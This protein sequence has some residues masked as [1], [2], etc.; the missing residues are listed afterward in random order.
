MQGLIAIFLQKGDTVRVLFFSVTA[1]GGHN[2][3]A[4][5]VAE[6]LAQQGVQ[7]KIVD[8][9]RLSG[10][11]MYYTVSRGYLLASSYLKYGYGAVYRVLEHR[12]G[13]A[14]RLSP[15]RL[16]GRSLAKK[17]AAVIREYDPDVVVC[18]H[19]FA[20]RILDIAKERH[21]FR[22]KT[23]GIVTDFTL[24]PYWEEALRLDRL[25]LACEGL[26]PLAEKKGFTA[27]QI[28]PT[29]IPVHSAF[30]KEEAKETARTAL[31]LS[32]TLPTLLIMGGS[33][34]Y[35]NMGKLLRR[36]DRLPLALQS[37]VVCGS[38]ERAAKSIRRH[39]PK[40]PVLVL[41]FVDFVPRLMAAA[42]L[43]I[44]KPGGLTT[45]EALSRRLPMIMTAAIPGHEANNAAFLTQAGTALP[46]SR[47]LSLEKAVL[48]LL[49]P[50]RRRK[51]QAAIDAIRRPNATEALC[52]EIFALAEEK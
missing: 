5:A 37:V 2:T 9:Y 35:G 21:G 23:V 6:A 52:R 19:P 36:L 12:R 50:E 26:T 20:G 13:N 25:I 38:N 39:P 30:A 27:A 31:G 18:T 11:F 45:S 7:T 48:S 47:R 24:H 43:I 16:S 40:N 46:L 33:M 49:D 1:G 14:Y 17:F 32:P 34:G 3:T 28:R 4:R 44:S 29:G 22:A 8:A 10:R 15:A 41:G 42:D 51:M